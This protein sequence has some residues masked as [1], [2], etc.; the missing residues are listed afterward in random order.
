MCEIILANPLNVELI[1]EKYLHENE[2]LFKKHLLHLNY[3]FFSAIHKVDFNKNESIDF[4][5][6]M[7]TFLTETMPPTFKEKYQYLVFRMTAS[8]KDSVSTYQKL[9]LEQNLKL[10][11][12]LSRNKP[13]LSFG[14]YIYMQKFQGHYLYSKWQSNIK[15]LHYD[16]IYVTKNDY[17]LVNYSLDSLPDGVEYID[18]VSSYVKTKNGLI[19]ISLNHFNILIDFFAGDNYKIPVYKFKI[20]H[21]LD[22]SDFQIKREILQINN[23]FSDIFEIIQDMDNYVCHFFISDFILPIDLKYRDF[24]N[25]LILFEAEFSRDDFLLYFGADISQADRFLKRSIDNNKI[26]ISNNSISDSLTYLKKEHE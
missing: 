11:L 1:N 7:E 2:G 15:N 21:F 13:K 14:D 5:S 24:S 10:S 18:L 16:S 23:R 19:Y 12:E 20:D 25:V 9:P 3:L 26:A 8:S 22:K 17:I 6:L 4:Y